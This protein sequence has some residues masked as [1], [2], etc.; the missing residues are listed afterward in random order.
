MVFL[1]YYSTFARK[2]RSRKQFRNTQL[3][4]LLAM[5]LSLAFGFILA[6]GDQIGNSKSA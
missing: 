6:Q 3:F 5:Q 4:L 2:F 1:A